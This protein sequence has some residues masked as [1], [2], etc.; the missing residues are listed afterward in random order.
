[1]RANCGCHAVRGYCGPVFVASISSI[2]CSDMPIEFNSFWI[3]RSCSESL[4]LRSIRLFCNS[5]RLAIRSVTYHEYPTTASSVITKPMYRGVVG[6]RPEE[7]CT[8]REYNGEQGKPKCLY[9]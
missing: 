1:M 7:C 3:R 2:P 9:R 4:R 5:R 8:W 6:E